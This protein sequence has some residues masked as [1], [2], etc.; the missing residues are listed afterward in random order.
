MVVNQ[1][2]QVFSSLYGSSYSQELRNFCP[3]TAGF[4]F[5]WIC[6]KLLSARTLAAHQ[7]LFKNTRDVEPSLQCKSRPNVP[8]PKNEEVVN[9]VFCSIP[10]ERGNKHAKSS[11]KVLDWWAWPGWTFTWLPLWRETHG[12]WGPFLYCELVKMVRLT[13]RTAITHLTLIT[14]KTQWK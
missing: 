8:R 13:W 5:V 6:K 12:S 3:W 7:H 2:L 9:F 1:G 11:A 10:E 14:R 4:K